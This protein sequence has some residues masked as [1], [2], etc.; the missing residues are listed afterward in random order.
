MQLLYS[1]RHL[2]IQRLP[3]RLGIRRLGQ[4]LSR[5]PA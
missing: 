5:L 1:Q 2:K 3:L 4:F